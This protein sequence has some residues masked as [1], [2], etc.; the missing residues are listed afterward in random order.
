MNIKGVDQY[1][2][3]LFL[4]KHGWIWTGIF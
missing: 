1:T 4:V 2:A 3:W